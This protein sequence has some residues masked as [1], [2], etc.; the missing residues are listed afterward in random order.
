MLHLAASVSFN[1]KKFHVEARP[2]LQSLMSPVRTAMF[3]GINCVEARNKTPQ[4]RAPK[5]V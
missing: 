2:F 5:D 1:S 3:C 4:P